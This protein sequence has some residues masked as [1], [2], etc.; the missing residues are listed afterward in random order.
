MKIKMFLLAF[1]LSICSMASFADTT[2]PVI[3]KGSFTDLSL[4]TISI[5]SLSDIT[6]SILYGTGSA[7][8]FNKVYSLVPA[9]FSGGSFGSST[10]SGDTFSFKNVVAGDYELLISGITS[11]VGNKFGTALIGAEYTVSAVPEPKTSGMFLA[12]LGII[13]F[14]AS[15]RKSLI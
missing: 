3:V 10:F 6:G 13:G 7:T 14:I 2:D 1:V 9:T 4:G 11:K 15:R 12:G 8:L 5:S